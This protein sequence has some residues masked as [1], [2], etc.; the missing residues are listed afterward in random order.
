VSLRLLYLI[1]VRLGGWLVLLGCPAASKDIE[2]LV[3]RHEVAVLRRAQPRPHLDWAGARSSPAHPAPAQKPAV[4][5]AGYPRYC[6]SLAPPPRR[7]E[8]DLSEQD[9]LSAGQH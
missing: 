9:R 3:L 8:V 4:A 6:A 5:P 2:L 7:P 1:F